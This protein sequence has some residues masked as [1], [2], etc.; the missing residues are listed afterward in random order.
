VRDLERQHPWLFNI[1]V[2]LVLGIVAWYLTHAWG[3]ILLVPFIWAP[4]RVGFLRGR[5]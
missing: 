5:T 2:G 1:V 3:A 4:L